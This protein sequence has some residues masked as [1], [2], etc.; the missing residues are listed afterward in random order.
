MTRTIF[1]TFLAVV[2]ASTLGVQSASAQCTPS[3]NFC[4]PPAGSP[5]G[6]GGA[7]KS[8][9]PKATTTTALRKGFNLPPVG[10]PFVPN[11]VILDVPTSVS[12]AQLNAI[13]GRHGMTRMETQTFR[14]TGRRLF[15]WRID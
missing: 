5:P 12:E 3:T 7:G 6:G 15:R 1:R 8:G 9:A 11:E 13:S 14:L 4:P 2:M 10:A